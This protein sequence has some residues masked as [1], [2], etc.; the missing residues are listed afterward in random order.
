MEDCSITKYIKEDNENSHL[1][2]ADN[3]GKIINSVKVNGKDMTIKEFKSNKGVDMGILPR[4][5][6][7]GTPER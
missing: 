7:L 3:A 5:K 2:N 4:K 1:F 6:R